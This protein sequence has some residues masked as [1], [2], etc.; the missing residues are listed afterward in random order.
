MKLITILIF[1]I[2]LNTFGQNELRKIELSENYWKTEN[3]YKHY[4]DLDSLN[5]SKFKYYFRYIKS[6]QIIDVYSNNGIDFSGKILN[7]TIQ[8][9][10]E[11][12]KHR[13]EIKTRS[14]IS[15]LY[16]LDKI[17][18]SEIGQLFIKHKINYIP[19]DTLI[20]NWRFGW[21]DCYG[22]SF[23][24]N[25]SDNFKTSSYS[26]LQGQYDT[27][28]YVTN[29]KTIIDSIN[30][31]LELEKKYSEFTSKLEGGCS[32]SA[33]GYMVMYITTKKESEWLN[34]D[35]P[36][37]DYLYSIKDTITNYLEIGLNRLITNT[38]ELDCYDDFYITFSKKGKF[39]KIRGKNISFFERI[40]DK[41]YR[42][43][44]RVVKKSLRKMLPAT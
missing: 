7:R 41:D 15:E 32:Y 30:S 40:S 6:K 2:S 23:E 19:T 3:Y 34:K 25:I 39:K 37:R 22:V 29:L 12:T 17:K 31:I 33:N 4:F 43:C 20:N 13:K 21:F 10:Q 16:E 42:K 26:C 14:Y 8:R 35:K 18:A 38:E 24:F 1:I 11:K 44:K 9:T 27:V 36:R 28:E 5:K